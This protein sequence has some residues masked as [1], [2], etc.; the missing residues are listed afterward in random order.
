MVYGMKIVNVFDNSNLNSHFELNK[1]I[2]TI[3]ILGRNTN[4]INKIIFELKSNGL[5]EKN[6]LLNK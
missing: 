4:M 2:R 1:I 3:D 6:Y 5:V